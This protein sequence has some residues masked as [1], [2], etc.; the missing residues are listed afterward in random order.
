MKHFLMIVVLIAV[1]ATTAMAQDIE[2]MM[3]GRA[4]IGAGLVSE[5]WLQNPAVLGLQANANGTVD[6]WQSSVSGVYEVEGDVDLRALTYGG[7]PMGQRWGVGAGLVDV[8]GMDSVGL[9][10]GFGTPDGRMAAGLNYQ[11]IDMSYG[12]NA[13][14]FDF[15]VSGMLPDVCSA[16]DSGMWG[17]VARDVGDQ[18]ERT[19]DLGIGFQSPDWTVAAD[20][21]DFSDEVDTI[22]Q[23]GV[24]R[25]FGAMRQWKVGA[26]VDDSNLTA[27][28][29][30]SP[31]VDSSVSP[32]N[33]GLAWLE[34]DN[35]A[36][37]AW[38]V[39]ASA[40]F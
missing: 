33:I 20:V 23:I 31:T 16:F 15:A 36:D 18:Y 30:Y 14:I 17:I 9:G 10:A 1:L 4:Q 5:A 19:F 11:S 34:G 21:E 7:Y 3:A 13:D 8:S 27:G 22:F 32:W 39:G 12:G 25:T 35:G 38:V 40:D 24:T 6:G 26:G 29:V 2:T 28:F 37:D